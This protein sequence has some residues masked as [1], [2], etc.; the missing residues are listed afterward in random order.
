MRDRVSI[1]LVKTL[2]LM[3]GGEG[4]REPAAGKS[5]DGHLYP[6]LWTFVKSSYY[7]R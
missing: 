5:Q 7:T 3:N 1:R 6:V 4:E 2:T